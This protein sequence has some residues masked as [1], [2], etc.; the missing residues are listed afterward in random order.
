[1]TI[2]EHIKELIEYANEFG[3]DVTLLFDAPSLESRDCTLEYTGDDIMI[4]IEDTRIYT[5]IE[6]D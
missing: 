5:D 4:T 3:W 2:G 1:M 6:V